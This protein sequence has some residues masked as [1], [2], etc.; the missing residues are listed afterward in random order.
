MSNKSTTVSKSTPLGA[1]LWL[2]AIFIGLVGQIAWVLENMYFATFAQTIFE[3]ATVFTNNEYYVATTLM[4]IFSAVTATLTTIFAGGLCD[5]TGKRKPFI[6]FGY[7]IWGL[8][9][10]L[11]MLIPT[12]FDP[13]KSA[14]IIAMLV[15]FDC[16]MTVAG[17]TSNDAAFNTWLTDVTDYSNRG[18]VNTIYRYCQSS[19]RFLFWQSQCSHSINP[20]TPYFSACWAQFR[21]R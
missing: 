20:I 14:G 19:P 16:I 17:S 13:K 21:L 9:I 18:R 4:V 6:S 3:D 8:A 15:I 2:N 5:K 12:S 11:F 7:I 1:K 10:F